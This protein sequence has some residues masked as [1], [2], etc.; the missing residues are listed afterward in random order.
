MRT[1]HGW[2]VLKWLRVNHGWEGS[3]SLVLANETEIGIV[4]YDHCSCADSH[5]AICNA[6]DN[7]RPSHGGGGKWRWQ[8]KIEDFEEYARED[9]TAICNPIPKYQKN[10]SKTPKTRKTRKTKTPIEEI[11]EILAGEK[12][13]WFETVREIVPS[14]LTTDFDCFGYN[15]H[16]GH[17]WYRSYF[18]IDDEQYTVQYVVDEKG[19]DVLSIRVHGP[20]S[21]SVIHVT[22]LKCDGK[23]RA[24]YLR[25]FP[26]RKY[27]RNMYALMAMM[28]HRFMPHLNLCQVLV[29]GDGGP[30][31]D[32]IKR[33]F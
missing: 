20:S 9:G 24:H 21:S 3:G 31:I 19:G 16:Y 32:E 14:A 10:P 18:N 30:L 27:R 8:G 1:F 17:D 22:A 7:Y 13:S 15:R 29:K 2:Y 28:M 5:E 23:P 6:M 4:D 11:P 25:G 12:H 33:L 26:E